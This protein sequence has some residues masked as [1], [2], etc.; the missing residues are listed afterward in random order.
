MS[1]ANPL[2]PPIPEKA[3]QRLV[4]GNLFG[5]SIGLAL[6][7][8]IAESK[9]PVVIITADTMTATRLEYEIPFFQ[10]EPLPVIH[11]SDWE[12]L[13][14]D[15]FSPHQ[16]I[17]SDRLAA[18]YKMPNLQ[19]GAIIT[20]IATL[21]HQLVPRDFLEG[22]IFLL[23]VGD[24]L[25]IDTT[26]RRL[27][28]GGY[29]CVSQVQEHGEYA[30]RGS[31]IDLY[32]MG[33]D[34]PY[35]IDLFDDDI[36]SIRTFSP[37]S[38]RSLDKVDKI[39]LLPAKEFPLT[40]EA[41]ELFRQNWRSQFTGNPL[42]CSMYEDITE[43]ICTPGIEYYLP[44]FFKATSTIFDYL[45]ENSL[46]VTVGDTHAK[47]E[48]FWQEIRARYEQR[49]YDITHPVLKPQQI[50]IS[51]PDTFSQIQNY[52]NIRIQSES[53]SDESNTQINFATQVPAT[54]SVDH[55]AAKP[56][57]ALEDFLVNYSGRILFCA[58]TTGRREVLLQLFNSI[59]LHPKLY[60]SWQEFLTDDAPAGMTVAPFR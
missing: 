31:I 54:L 50:F 30:V 47:A 24:K 51:T 1:I 60:S 15:H 17:I 37:E 2:H 38:Q 7:T 21:M 18:L 13:P 29:R 32:P 53:V 5:S 59:Q 46:I 9:R 6:S 36:D 12:T 8:L 39:E 42:N 25:N 49:A 23:S 11:F 26:R 4:W 35:R 33:S 14:Y 45:P 34:S 16:D 57:Q 22:N 58:E 3:K 43:G 10:S 44:L 56:L 40:D 28:R 19:Q 52:T 55:K 41:I 27:E 48:D 20:S